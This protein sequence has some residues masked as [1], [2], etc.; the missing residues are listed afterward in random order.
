MGKRKRAR[1]EGDL[2]APGGR[3]GRLGV[4]GRVG[5]LSV[6]GDIR[7]GAPHGCLLERAVLPK[8]ASSEDSSGAPGLR[9][10]LGMVGREK[11]GPE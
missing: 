10:V 1:L 8:A 5:V 7:S 4:G 11:E 9:G 3:A 6:R 2:P